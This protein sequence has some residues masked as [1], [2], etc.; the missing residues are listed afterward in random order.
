VAFEMSAVNMS[1]STKV[2]RPATPASSAR[3][4]ESATISGLYS[5]PMARAPRRAAAMTLRPSPEPRSITRSPAV[6]C[7]MSSIFSTSAGGVGTHT[8]SLPP[9][10]ISGSYD[11]CGVCA[12]AVAP[13]N[14]TSDSAMSAARIRGPRGFPRP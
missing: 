6:T 7:A 11:F 1:P 3:R 12:N 8:T 14:A 13:D 5:T 2:A 10:P 4:V 9:W